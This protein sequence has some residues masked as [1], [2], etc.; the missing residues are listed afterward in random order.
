MR[1]FL[2]P[3][4]NGAPPHSVPAR[5]QSFYV[6]EGTLSAHPLEPQTFSDGARRDSNGMRH[7]LACASLF[8]KKKVNI[9]KKRRERIKKKKEARLKRTTRAALGL[10]LKYT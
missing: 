7:W 1:L 2:L 6:P 3:Q 10:E 4:G 9:V 8:H 5:Q